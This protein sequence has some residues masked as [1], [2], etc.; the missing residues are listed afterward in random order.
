MALSIR[1]FI[2][3]QLNLLKAHGDEAGV[4]DDQLW[5]NLKEMLNALPTYVGTE[6]PILQTQCEKDSIKEILGDEYDWDQTLCKSLLKILYWM[7]GRN[8]DGKKQS[9]G[10][11][12][13]PGEDMEL[14][15]RCIAGNVVIWAMFEKHCQLEKMMNYAVQNVSGI[16]ES[17]GSTEP[18]RKCGDHTFKDLK[19]G[20][21]FLGTLVKDWVNTNKNFL[22]D[23]KIV[24]KQKSTKCR[25]KGSSVNGKSAADDSKLKNV[26]GYDNSGAKEIEEIVTK[27]QFLTEKSAK[28]VMGKIGKGQIEDTDKIEQI[29][30]Q[31]MKEQMEAAANP[32]LS[33]D[34]KNC[35]ITGLEDNEEDTWDTVLTAF[36]NN[37]STADGNNIYDKWEKYSSVCEKDAMTD[38]EWTQGE[39][40]FCKILIRN[41]I[42]A[43]EKKFECEGKKNKVPG[44]YCVTKCD[45][46][47]MWLMYVKDRC[48]SSDIIKYAYEAMYNLEGKLGEGQTGELCEYGKFSRI[49]R[50]TGDVLHTVTS[51]MICDG[52]RGKLGEIHNKDWCNDTNKKYTKNLLTGAARSGSA[53]AE[54]GKGKE[55]IEKLVQEEQKLGG[56]L[57]EVKNEVV[58]QQPPL[59]SGPPPPPVQPPATRQ[60]VECTDKT[61]LCERANCAAT[62]WFNDRNGRNKQ[63]WCTFWDPDAINR[64]KELSEG[65]MVTDTT[66]D[67]ACGGTD[68]KNTTWGETEKAACKLIASGLKHIYS[69]QENKTENNT[70]KARNNRLTEQTMGCL[71]L[72]AYADKLI[73]EV[74]RPCNITEDTIKEAFNRGN[75]KKVEWCK[76][77]KANSLNCVEC[78]RV[79][80]LSCALS[81]EEDLR[82][83][84]SNCEKDNDNI[85]KKVQEVFKKGEADKERPK[86]KEA[87]TAI[88][89][90]NNINNNLCE[91]TKCVTVKWFENRTGGEGTGTVKQDWCTFWDTDVKNQL[92]NLSNGML[93][94]KD[95]VDNECSNI[96]EV[97]NA[98]RKA[99]NYIVRGLKHIYEIKKGTDTQKSDQWKEDNLIFHRTVSCV[100]LNSFVD[101]LEEN[102]ECPIRE[103]IIAQA[104]QKGNE[105]MSEWC[106][107]KN[108][109]GSDCAE[110]TRVKNLTCTVNVNGNLW[111]EKNN[112]QNDK[113]NVRNKVEGLFKNNDANIQKAMK[114]ATDI[115][116]KPEAP[117]TPVPEPAKPEAVRPPAAGGNSSPGR[118]EDTSERVPVP[119]P[120]AP[121]REDQAAGKGTTENAKSD[122]KYIDLFRDVPDYILKG[123]SDNSAVHN[124]V[125]EDDGLGDKFLSGT[126]SITSERANTSVIDATITTTSGPGPIPPDTSDDSQT[127]STGTDTQTP[128]A[129]AGK[130]SPAQ[131]GPAGNDQT[132]QGAGAD[133]AGKSVAGTEAH[134]GNSDPNQ[135][136]QD[137][138]LSVPSAG[139]P[140]GRTSGSKASA[141][142]S[143][144]VLDECQKGDLHSTK[145]DFFEIL[146]REF[147]G[148]NFIEEENVPE[149]HV[150]MVD[151]PK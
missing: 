112:C 117:P 151:A 86:I 95:N 44:K 93:Q 103:D 122:G 116:P 91:R 37:P 72:N 12:T 31:K 9:M 68:G 81:V 40:T 56:K 146:V 69:V 14:M 110:C 60:G 105:K 5:T 33:V 19:V 39:K 82:K 36:S 32:K 114:A 13:I 45:L 148:R 104:F 102:K 141:P 53:G 108:R 27:E 75:K 3:H 131:A 76:D 83:Q 43:N 99:C 50:D 54:S 42:L 124:N 142:K 96:G 134:P 2:E 65:M 133:P 18:V 149:E 140:D 80:N 98:S 101:K 120:P 107:D 73:K 25:R 7:N 113:G 66:I 62:N 138:S 64:L 48:V 29:I 84:D 26:G 52:K 35:T 121:P 89:T 28:E 57:D 71:F 106:V 87:L 16:L 135:S 23:Y 10:R 74:R 8:Q 70:V 109:G 125:D 90:I 22:H 49:A 144:E 1:K 115:C 55:L 147:M 129:S 92:V 78:T 136:V 38:K 150:S 119:P 59:P 6:V 139:I 24:E 100:L 118:S 145:E 126:W 15:F 30:Q 85:E 11:G 79:P 123:E 63:D 21:Q 111:K 46:L 51:K 143:P 67:T 127:P 94:N 41:L 4:S 77:E 20:T 128:S 132:I 34:Q 88:N 130:T 58:K 61:D 137:P 17:F 47:N 97:G